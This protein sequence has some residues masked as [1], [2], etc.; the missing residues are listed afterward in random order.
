MP[1]KIKVSGRGIVSRS[2]KPKADISVK[3][4]GLGEKY[5]DINVKITRPQIF[6][7]LGDE[8]D[9]RPKTKL[10]KKDLIDLLVGDKD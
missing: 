6:S 9:Y 3:D 7:L 1:L 8:R 10:Y 2:S 5:E 4:S